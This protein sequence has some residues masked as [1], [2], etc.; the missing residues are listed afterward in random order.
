MRIK[1]SHHSAFTLLE[2]LMAS[3]IFVISVLGIFATLNAV[4]G[5]VSNK[6]SALT[7]TVFGKQVLEALSSQVTA[8]TY[9][10]NTCAPP[11]CTTFDLSVGQHLVPTASLPAGV[12]WPVALTQC[13]NGLNYKV[14]C[15][16]GSAAGAAPFCGGN[17]FI[18][19]KVDLNINWYNVVT[20][21][22]L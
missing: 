16:D 10:T 15:A 18:A 5:P 14:S 1:S 9:Y 13:N 12:N 19:R 6:E 3:L 4:R 22:C 2:V 7:A 8:A 20:G 21:N 17:Y 11:P